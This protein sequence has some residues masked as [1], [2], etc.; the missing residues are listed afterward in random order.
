MTQARQLVSTF[1]R[2]PEGRRLAPP[3]AFANGVVAV[4]QRF[5]RDEI[6][7]QGHYRY[8]QWTE[9]L[10]SDRKILLQVVAAT[11]SETTG[12]DTVDLQRSVIPPRPDAR[13]FVLACG[14]NDYFG[15]GQIQQLDFAV[16]NATTIATT[17]ERS[18]RGLYSTKA[19]SLLDRNATPSF[20]HHVTRSYA[21]QLK[22]KVSPDDVLVIF[23]S[24]H[25]WRDEE[26]SK[27]YFVTGGARSADVRAGRYSDCM[28][29][30][31]IAA[32]SDVPCR[33]LVILDTCHS[34][35]IG[36]SRESARRYK[37]LKTAL[38]ALQEDVV[39]TMTASQGE[40][41]AVEEKERGLGRFTSHLIAAISGQADNLHGGNQDG[42]VSL[43]EAIRYVKATVADD[44]AQSEF[45]QHPTAG[46][47]E[48]LR[49]V[50]FPLTQPRA[51]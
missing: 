35:A 25:G 13:L 36:E 51:R 29:F 18:T 44:S 21:D 30:E 2:A 11:D 9:P 48:L 39:L 41:D 45:K 26:T 5:V 23:L 43:Q 37:D 46:P 47:A 38:R 32:F 31:D 12:F 17:F 6:T 3:K 14:V 42:T 34:G 22:D 27:Y 1:R 20:W 28:S 8:Y 50:D 4:R 33:K 16:N 15:D 49:Y 19:M 7:A 40:E 24:G 10:P